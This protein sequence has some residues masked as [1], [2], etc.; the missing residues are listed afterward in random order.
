MIPCR[1]RQMDE[2]HSPLG[3]AGDLIH[4]EALLRDP[5]QTLSANDHPYIDIPSQGP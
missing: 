2:D 3:I 5:H 4:G 1:N